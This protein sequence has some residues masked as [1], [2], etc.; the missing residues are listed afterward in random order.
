[1][2]NRASIRGPFFFFFFSYV[3]ACLYPVVLW[4][5]KTGGVD[6]ILGK[7]GSDQLLTL[8]CWG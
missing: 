2:E 1:M 3:T 4:P 6:F 5:S 7:V 8:A